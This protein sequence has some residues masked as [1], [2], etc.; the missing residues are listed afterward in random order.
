MRYILFPGSR[1]LD[2]RTAEIDRQTKERK[3]HMA[4][5]RA[6]VS[7]ATQPDVLRNLVVSMQGRKQ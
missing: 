4:E 3:E 7:Q 2:E 6:L 5:T 1:L